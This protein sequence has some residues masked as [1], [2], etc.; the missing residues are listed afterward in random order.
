MKYCTDDHRC[1]HATFFLKKYCY[2]I[3][4][5][6]TELLQEIN[7]IYKWHSLNFAVISFLLMSLMVLQAQFLTVMW[8]TFH[9]TTPSFSPCISVWI[10]SCVY[11][12][13]VLDELPFFQLNV[14]QVGPMF[15]VCIGGRRFWTLNLLKGHGPKK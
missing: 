9:D 12:K 13:L 1:V 2:C 6:T 15:N 7:I 5:F 3:T 8:L 14:F 11:L 4:S 10:F